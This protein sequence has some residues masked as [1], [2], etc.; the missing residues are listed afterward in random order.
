VRRRAARLEEQG[1]M[2]LQALLL[3][4]DEVVD[5]QQS[6]VAIPRRITAPM[7]EMMVMQLRL[8]KTRGRRVLGLIGQARF[9]AA[10]DFLCLRALA[11]DADP[12]LAEFWT[13]LQAMDAP[14][15]EAAV[16]PGGR[17]SGGRSRPAEDGAAEGAETAAVTEPAEKRRRRRRPRRRKPGGSGAG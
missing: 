4:A 14:A 10:Y 1:E 13:G 11:G 7:K 15:R 5:A 8:Q 16:D 3:A 6:Y 9:R 12:A 17:R 2:P